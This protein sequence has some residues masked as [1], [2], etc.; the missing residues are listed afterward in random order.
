MFRWTDHRSTQGHCFVLAAALLPSV[1]FK[2]RRSIA[3]TALG[4]YHSGHCHLYNVPDD[5][6]NEIYKLQK[7]GTGVTFRRWT[8]ACIDKQL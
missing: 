7:G 6:P 2:P 4:D 1:P 5:Q 8:C 3:A